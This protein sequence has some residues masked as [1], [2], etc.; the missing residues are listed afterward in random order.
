M[1]RACAYLLRPLACVRLRHRHSSN[2]LRRLILLDVAET[3]DCIGCVACRLREP[4]RVTGVSGTCGLHKKVLHCCVVH[5]VLAPWCCTKAP[6][7]LRC[8]GA[9]RHPLIGGTEDAAC[10]AARPSRYRRSPACGIQMRRPRATQAPLA[11]AALVS[12]PRSFIT[13]K[14]GLDQIR[15][16]FFSAQ[17]LWFSPVPT[18]ETSRGLRNL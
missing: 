4:H 5:W 3:G 12:R 16:G 11:G 1:P 9:T 2:L 18:S 13:L 7:F 8:D 6:R 14:P 17:L 10:T 15:R